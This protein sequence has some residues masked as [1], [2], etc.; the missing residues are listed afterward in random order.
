MI[1][2]FKGKTPTHES[3]QNASALPFITLTNN[4]SENQFE[5]TTV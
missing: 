2:V 5:L 4:S 1:P 3:N